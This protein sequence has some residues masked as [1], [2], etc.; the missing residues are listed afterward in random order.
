MGKHKVLENSTNEQNYDPYSK[1]D[2]IQAQKHR[3]AHYI[4]QI[5][6]ALREP[7]SEKCKC[8]GF[9]INA[10]P[11]P[12]NCNMTDLSELGS[13]FPLYFVFS[14]IVGLILMLGI[15]IVAIPCVIGNS[16]PDQADDW[17][18]DKDSWIIQVSLGNYG[19]VDKIYPMWQCGLHV[20][21][22]VL[23]ILIYHISRRWFEAKD[24]DFDIMATTAKDYTVHAYGLGNDMSEQ[25]VKEFFELYGRYDKKQAKIVKVVFAYKI[26][27]Y[28]DNLRK[29]EEHAETLRMLEEYEKQGIVIKPRFWSKRIPSKDNIKLEI[30]NVTKDLKKYED[31]LPAGVGRDLLTGQAFITFETQ[32]DA[33]AVELKYGRQWMYRLWDSTIRVFFCCF[34]K[35]NTQKF[36]NKRIR[37]NIA[38]E[39]NDIFWENLE[40]SFH[41]RIISTFKTSLFTLFAVSITFG[42]VYGMKV[43]SRQEK[44]NY[45][46]NS[47][48]QS[49]KIRA[50]SIWPSIVIVM[51]NFILARSTRYSTSFERPHSLTAYN[52]SVAFKLTFAMFFNTAVIALIVNFEWRKDW[53]VPGGLVTDATYILISNAFVSPLLYYFSPMLCVHKLKMRKVAK[54]A[55]ISQHD[56][57]VLI[58]NPE[59]DMAQRFANITKTILLTFCYAPLVPVGFIF[60]ALAIFLEYWTFKYLLLRRHSWPKKLSGDLA[61]AVFNII[62]WSVL[63]Y[64]V[65][66]FVYMNF[67]NPD[68]SQ[69]AFYWMC[70]MIGYNFLPLE[71]FAALCISKDVTTWE[72]TSAEKYDEVALTFVEDYDKLNP[73]TSSEGHKRYAELMLKKD[74]VNKDEFE[75]M[76]QALKLK[77][78]NIF[79]N[80]RQYAKG[81][82][83]L[84][85]IEKKK[86]GLG[87]VSLGNVGKAK[88]VPKIEK[89]HKRNPQFH[90]QQ[91]A[92]RKV[93]PIKKKMNSDKA[94]IDKISI[95]YT[96]LDETNESKD[97]NHGPYLNTK[98][99]SNN[100]PNK[101]LVSN[102]SDP[103]PT[104]INNFLPSQSANR[105]TSHAARNYQTFFKPSQSHSYYNNF[106]SNKGSA[107]ETTIV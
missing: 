1:A 22:M 14:R 19:D 46:K 49:W 47:E 4:R 42:M 41:D 45:S 67:L 53:F 5:G 98:P 36:H 100:K 104:Y 26:K 35:P 58:E 102:K 90:M 84:H 56:A 93:S 71:V 94:I 32:A 40:V 72:I 55:Y 34:S 81:R 78:D 96:N 107:K 31:E 65:M 30:E 63:L 60:S 92:H 25:E 24:R 10:D 77:T 95:V 101:K 73:I 52:I 57:N 15:V 83:N 75:E 69:I 2:M 105:K 11:F 6:K 37:A 33:R 61:K 3:Q 39:P 51:I 70:I 38:Y 44:E 82:E 85:D 7:N 79:T 87:I 86:L 76:T 80:M 89:K 91:A 106:K 68:Q 17:H 54:A 29:L 62:P 103:S 12:L 23:I 21:F 18:A 27:E 99:S 13:G 59:V 43:L 9:P 50:I 48:T 88:K 64:A 66:N 28:I 97:H 8:C 20:G 74:V 16:I